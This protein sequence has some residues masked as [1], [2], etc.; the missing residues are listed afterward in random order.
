MR[1]QQAINLKIRKL[2]ITACCL[3][4]CPNAHTSLLKLTF[5]LGILSIW[6]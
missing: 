2:H 6:M 5:N 3:K 4:K 1:I